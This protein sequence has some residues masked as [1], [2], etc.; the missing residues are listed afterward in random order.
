M[1]RVAMANPNREVGGRELS[2]P[3]TLGVVIADTTLDKSIPSANPIGRTRTA[4]FTLAGMCKDISPRL[5]FPV[6]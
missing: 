1:L 6:S 3:V 4:S 2:T 5:C